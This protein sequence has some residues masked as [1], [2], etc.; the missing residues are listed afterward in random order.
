MVHAISRHTPR[1][2]RSGFGRP[3]LLAALL[4]WSVTALA[5]PGPMFERMDRNDDGAIDA[6]EAQ[7]ARQKAFE[8]MD[9]DGDGSLTRDELEQRR[10]RA[11]QKGEAM[12]AKADRDDDGTVT[13]DEFMAMPS[14]LSKADQD[15]DGR[16]TAEEAASMRA[17]MKERHEQ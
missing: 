7:M 16:V 9:V 6:E 13:R 4:G 1:S 11:Q 3:L 12:F 5:Q 15:G 14:M 10:K 17:H 2:S 8:R